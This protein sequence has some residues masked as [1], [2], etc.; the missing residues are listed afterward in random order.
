MGQAYPPAI[1][2]PS[3]DGGSAPGRRLLERMPVAL[4]LN[5]PGILRIPW[6]YRTYQFDGGGSSPGGAAETS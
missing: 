1:S 3:A 2:P 4:D 5:L 6:L